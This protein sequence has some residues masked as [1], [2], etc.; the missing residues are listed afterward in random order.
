VLRYVTK[1][2]RDPSFFPFKE[3]KETSFLCRRLGAARKH[4]AGVAVDRVGLDVAPLQLEVASLV[5]ARHG[6]QHAVCGEVRGEVGDGA[7][8]CAAGRVV[9][10]EQG[11]EVLLAR[12]ALQTQRAI[13]E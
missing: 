10:L 8:P 4:L 11:K 7:H 6:L 3:R 13:D 5:G 9:L 12:R 2:E 1:K